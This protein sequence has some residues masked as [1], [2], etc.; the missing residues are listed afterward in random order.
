MV[1]KQK[2]VRIRHA[3]IG[4]L[5]VYVGFLYYAKSRALLPSGRQQIV[6]EITESFYTAVERQVKLVQGTFV[7]HQPHAVSPRVT[8]VR[9]A[10]AHAFDGYAKHAWG[11]DELMPVSQRGKNSFCQSGATIIDSLSTLWLANLT[12]RFEKARDWALAN[13]FSKLTSC[14]LFET[15]IRIVGGLLSAGALSNDERLYRQAQ[16]I[17]DLMLP[18]FE[19]EG[20]IP[21][22]TFPQAR[23]DCS[24]A[25]LA[26]AGTLI[27][28]FAFLSQVT[29]DERYQRAAE[30]A[31]RSIALGR[32]VS[33]CMPGLYHSTVE[34]RS[35]RGAGSCWAS[36]GGG[37]DSF[38][39]YLLKIYLLTNEH[40]SFAPYKRMWDLSMNS[41]YHNL[42]RCSNRHHM[43]IGAG[44]GN[45]FSSGLE[46][47]ACFIGGNMVLGNP[48][49]YARVAAAVTESCVAMYTS[50]TTGLG[51]DGVEWVGSAA[52]ETCLRQPAGHAN[53]DLRISSAHNLQRPETVESLYYLWLHT[54]DTRYRELGWEIFAKLNQ[55]RIASGGYASVMDVNAQAL[56]FDDL[57]QSFFI[58]EELKYLL[59]LFAET[60]DI[61]V[62]MQNWVFNTEAHPLPKFEPLFESSIGDVCAGASYVC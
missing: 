48:V 20:G 45:S 49:K 26:E 57:Q 61:P 62:D 44:D 16:V 29:R 31:M 27:M 9:N 33:T 10:I 17:A 60:A 28:E 42:L 30:R 38:Y 47:L 15:T 32:N 52:I 18:S 34:T 41:T 58:A 12:S 46:H 24:T 13:D 6:S 39:E 19:N 55:T 25:N 23:G 56:R 7:D 35:G 37:A 11:F 14:N 59:L 2:P 8:A 4:L 1:L 5:L 22:N 43:Y 3:F 51:A 21:C 53:A 50:T 40:A 54:K 36:M